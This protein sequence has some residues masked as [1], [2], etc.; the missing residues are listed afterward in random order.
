M[1]YSS[2]LPESG[3]KVGFTQL[4]I[5]TWAVSSYNGSGFMLT[6]G[7]AVG[8]LDCELFVGRERELATFGD[9]LRAD[10]SAPELLNV[11]GAS[12]VGKSA[13][14]RAFYRAATELGVPARLV[15][16]RVF[17]TGHDALLNVLGGSREPALCAQ[18][19]ETRRLILL[20]HFEEMAG[21]ARHLWQKFLPRLKTSVKVVIAG[22]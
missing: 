11:S 3:T 21:L 9:W 2:T 19:N 17:P 8:R 18:L 1:T 4:R 15:D 16:A 7:E 14:M 20:D 10:R 12:G 6:Y 22:R 13:L 5:D